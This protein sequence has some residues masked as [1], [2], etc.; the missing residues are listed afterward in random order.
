MWYTSVYT[1]EISSPR[2][3]V[4]VGS[5]AMIGGAVPR[6]VLTLLGSCTISVDGTPVE[7]FP[8]AKTSA[9][10]LYL[11]LESSVHPDSAHLRRVL[12]GLLWPEI[13]EQFALQNLRN[14]L[15]HLRQTLEQAGSGLCETLL[16]VTRQQIRFNSAQAE[17]DAVTFLA[18]ITAVS[19]HAHESLHGCD[20]C[21]ERLNKAMGL[22]Q[23]ELLAGL[24]L[25]DAPA[26]EEWLLLY[27]EL[28]HQ[29]A[30]QVVMWLVETYETRAALDEAQ[31]WARR[32]VE[33]DPFREDSHRQLM[34]IH[35]KQN[36]P[37]LALAHYQKLRRLFQAELLGELNQQTQALAQQI[38]AGEFDSVQGRQSDKVSGHAAH[39]ARGSSSH[40]VIPSPDL[41]D[42]PEVTLLWGRRRERTQLKHWLLQDHCRL[43]ALLGIGG[44]GKTTLAAQCVRELATDSGRAMFAAILWRSLLNAPPLHE[45]LPPILQILSEQQL[46]NVSTSVDEQIRLFM[47]YL[48][49]KRV[50][51]VLDNMESILDAEEAGTYRAGYEA[52]GQLIQQVATHHHQSHLLFTSRER[53]RSYVRLEGDTP[54]VRALEVTGLDDEAGRELLAQR[55]I[56]GAG[57]EA[58]TL[59]QR[60][61]GNP[62][63]LKLVA[64]T[65]EEIF[66]GDI[67]AFLAEET[68][69]FSDIRAVLD[70]QFARLSWLEQQLLY[71]LAVEREPTPAPLLR[72]NLLRPAAHYAFIEALHNLQR[73]SLL[74]RHPSGF[75][76]QNVVTEYLTDRLVT[77]ACDEI[78]SGGL[79]LLHHV[80]LVKATSKAHCRESQVR[81]ILRPIGDT[82][83][84]RLGRSAL[85][86]A[87]ERCLMQLRQQGSDLPS[88][89]AGNLLNLL[90]A[91]NFDLDGEDFSNLNVRQAY[92]QGTAL[93]NV[94]FSHA[95]FTESIFTNNFGRVKTLAISPDSE[96]LALGTDDGEVRLWRL[97]DGQLVRML[98]GHRSL[99]ISV[100]F[101]PDGRY[102]ASSSSLDGTIYLWDV[103]RGEVLATFQGHRGGVEVVTFSPDGSLVA[104]GGQD[105]TI[106]LWE[107]TSG[108][109]L[110]V[111]AKHTDWVTALA[112]HPT[113]ELLASSAM[114]DHECYL[115]QH[116]RPTELDSNPYSFLT[117]LRGHEAPV[118]TLSFSPHGSLLATGSK[119][120]MVRLWDI[121]NRQTIRVLHGHQDV[122]RTAVFS[123]DGAVL[124]TSGHDFTIR[125][126]EVAS[127]QLLQALYRHNH[128]IWGLAISADGKVL[129]SGGSDG[130]V[131]LWDLAEPRRVQAVRTLHG[132]V[133]PI[134]ALAISPRGDLFATGEKDGAVRLWQLSPSG[135]KIQPLRI[136]TGHS[137][138]VDSLAFSPDGRWLASGAHDKSVRLWDVASGACADCMT[139][140]ARA[141]ICIAFHPNGRMLACGISDSI[142]LWE[143]SKSGLSSTGGV[144]QGHTQDVRRVTF[145]PDGR[146]LASSSNDDTVRLWALDSACGAGECL[147]IFDQEV[148]SFWS[149]VFSPDGHFLAGG[150]RSGIYVW[151]LRCK[152]R[153]SIAFSV[154]AETTNVRSVAFSA[155][156]EQLVSGGV[157]R[158]IRVWDLK[159][160]AELHALAGHAAD[161]ISTFFLPDGDTIVSAGYDGTIRLWDV[162]N[163]QGRDYCRQMSRIPGPYEGMNITGAT[164]ISALQRTTLIA[165]GAVE[166]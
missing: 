6:L 95:Q 86:K 15:Y 108:R 32:L 57:D 34:R 162:G 123:P 31:H 73:R 87:I 153:P 85:H 119:D 98:R 74:E 126:W 43:V 160:G 146:Y 19:G 139:A 135:G 60:Y 137:A 101:S 104:S 30:L 138:L 7:H 14:T 35:A 91:L 20:E 115:W 154:R 13:G 75:A 113:G 23:G 122:V 44:V 156:G 92:L 111:L 120:G 112:F 70:Q 24:T 62:L 69:V 82:L 72:K 83:M 65:V 110:Q 55:G 54:F 25:P 47:C 81:Q 150:G 10:L 114:A 51:L 142:H 16:H 18:S 37:H 158:M 96:L 17:I 76:L 118:Q 63:A 45:L 39:P 166:N 163:A 61:S 53:P 164:G 149:V 88:Y 77:I 8:T 116:R 1:R 121:T 59:I 78:E 68:L 48:R 132:Y 125:L 66:G 12:A 127:G 124:V 133:R 151:D 29:R 97:L 67:T 141:G 41:S 28:Y 147:H 140:P 89:A 71:W 109:L 80:A 129:A 134:Y 117:E 38:A 103:V 56:Y 128:Q 130:V 152:Q 161:I 33:L 131:H 143:V 52:Y 84:G 58:A 42:V 100:A 2:N 99:V 36:A 148:R 3:F 26:F 107:A 9:L 49:D 21:L 5:T 165:L 157:D 22:Y 64:E 93:P 79:H 136:L 46:T 90:L 105:G 144:L 4:T 102:L 40:L 159:D 106:R 11:A 155:T 145:S 27:R 50:L 94:D